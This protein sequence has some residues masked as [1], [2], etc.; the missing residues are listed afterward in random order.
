[1]QPELL[2]STMPQSLRAQLW[3][4]RTLLMPPLNPTLPPMPTHI[5]AR[6]LRCIVTQ[7]PK[8][9]Q[10]GVMFHN[11]PK[12]ILTNPN[13]PQ[14]YGTQSASHPTPTNTE[15]TSVTPPALRSHLAYPTDSQTTRRTLDR[16]P[17][18]CP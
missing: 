3:T 14:C 2:V 5:Q 1:M 10:M 11:T 18:A 12:L 7:R 6:F 4:M 13:C 15:P 16:T 8:R 9:S 17:I